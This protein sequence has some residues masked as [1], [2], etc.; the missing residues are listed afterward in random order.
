M[1]QPHGRPNASPAAERVASGFDTN[2]KPNLRREGAPHLPF[3]SP[4]VGRCARRQPGFACFLFNGKL[5]NTA[6]WA[7]D[8]WRL[9]VN[10]QPLEVVS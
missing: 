3:L 2:S 6:P 1:G 4:G 5:L 9:S 8:R 10:H 7:T